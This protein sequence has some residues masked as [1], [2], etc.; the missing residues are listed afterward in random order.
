MR[1]GLLLGVNRGDWETVRREAALAEDAGFDIAWVGD[2]LAYPPGAQPL[3]SL[4]VLGAVAALTS[5]IDLAVVTAAVSFRAPA[6]LAKQ[7]TTLQH[8]SGGRVS[9]LL[10]SGV[11]EQEHAAFGL[12][13]GSPPTRL[14]R[15]EE[16]AEIC[17]RMWDADGAPVAFHGEMFVVDGASDRPPAPVRTPLGIG[18]TGRQLIR[19]A[20][21]VADEWCFGLHPDPGRL[22]ERFEEACATAARSVAC[23]ALVPFVAPDARHPLAEHPRNL[24]RPGAPRRVEWY[25][26][27][28]VSTL[29]MVPVGP[30]AAELLA[31]NLPD[32]RAAAG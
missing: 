21:R 4:T 19:L 30:G 12:A 5:A 22:L 9:C 32:L 15:L 24:N 28:G 1:F 11:D 8:V 3:E 7:I 17:R 2:H 20:A 27:A 26:S 29:Y 23:S 10:G 16:Y 25:R 13:F 31:R 14:R 18:G 6:V